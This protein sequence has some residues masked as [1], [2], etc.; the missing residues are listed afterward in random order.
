MKQ[1]KDTI[2]KKITL[3][4]ETVL[5]SMTEK[6]SNAIVK[7][8]TESGIK[9][10]E[11]DFGFAWWK[12]SDNDEYQLAYKS[13]NTP[14]NPFLPRKKASHYTAIRTRKPFFDNNVKKTSYGKSDISPYM[15]SFVIIPIYHD[16]NIYGSLTLCYKK[17]HKFT[18]EESTL[19]QAIGHTTAQA[20][21]I[22][23]L[24][25]TKVLLSQERLRTEFIG[26]ATH[27][28]RTPLAIMKG[29]VD[30]AL[31]DKA[32][33]KSAYA[34]LHEINGEIKILSN[35]LTDLTLLTSSTQHA[36]YIVKSTP[37]NVENLI[38][39]LKKRLERIAF[40]KK[41][42]IKVS[43]G[44]QD[45]H[46]LGD[47]KYLEKLFLNL[48]KNAI[49]YGKNGGNVT[50]TISKKNKMIKIEVK[51]NGIGISKEDLSKIF[52]RF[53]RAD[54]AH[55]SHG[56]HSGLGL[57]IAKWATEM[58]GGKIQAESTYGK[59]STFTVTL[60]AIN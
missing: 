39:K 50:I 6:D 2:S 16:N 20:I 26:N 47:E 22:H 58:H 13:P 11:A 49:A 15:R 19:S 27:E 40:E 17:R 48:I 60:P 55:S 5:D 52:D 45:L 9:I 43:A 7:N 44:S 29:N 23:K 28:L 32:N 41:I 10:L 1:K 54:K 36:R 30:L 12:F 38:K 18:E 59:G 35:I 3:L 24:L 57:A 4:N 31:M 21:T 34:A 46:V 51:D 25:E 56:I 33:L 14:Y 53:Y 8:F 42:T 37:V